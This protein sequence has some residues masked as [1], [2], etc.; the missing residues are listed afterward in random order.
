VA[1]LE[2]EVARQ[3]ARAERAEALVDLQKKVSEILGIELKRNG[4]KG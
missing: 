2:R 4:G 3:K 1:H